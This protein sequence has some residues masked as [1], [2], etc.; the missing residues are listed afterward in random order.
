MAQL[1]VGTRYLN[2]KLSAGRTCRTDRDS[3]N[4]TELWST[5]M[6]PLI[7]LV[8][9]RRRII[10]GHAV[11][12]VTSAVS[13]GLAAPVSVAQQIFAPI[14]ES[15]TT[16]EDL[17]GIAGAPNGEMIAVGDGAT[18]L[19]R[20]TDPDGNPIWSSLGTW[21]AGFF[22]AEIFDVAYSP[23]I[24]PNGAS[25]VIAGR[26]AVVETDFT[27][28]LIID[29]RPGSGAIF[30]PVL[31]TD[32]EVWYGV[33]DLG[34]FP[35]FLHRYDR[36]TQTAP[37]IAF[38][39]G[40]VLAMC[41]VPGGNLR[42]VTTDGDIAEI[43]DS[44]QVTTLFDQDD[45]DPLGLNAASFSDD[46]E[47]ISGGDAGPESRIYAAA[48][49]GLLRDD[50]PDPWEFLRQPGAPPIT[51]MVLLAGPTFPVELFSLGL[52]CSD[53]PFFGNEVMFRIGILGLRIDNLQVFN[54]DEKC[55]RDAALVTAPRSRGQTSARG[56]L[57]SD[58]QVLSVGVDGRAQRLPV[59]TSLFSDNFET[60]DLSA[61]SSTSP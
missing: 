60:G 22:S 52:R 34:T 26:D 49:G 53:T 3:V 57:T 45:G 5:S 8:Q 25:W 23:V 40:P 27:T 4:I 2:E 33:P 56:T 50:G 36:T 61:W 17:N 15:T 59:A 24:Y 54:E 46:C 55:Q 30:T 39:L 32:D 43:D 6:S 38:P 7:Q 51:A 11:I 10:A 14:A 29:Q 47:V 42:F 44:L 48:V 41:Q 12:L 31:P 28:N 13:L 21:A 19:R 18:V 35:S 16:T 1:W 9:I 20:T 37:G 58:F